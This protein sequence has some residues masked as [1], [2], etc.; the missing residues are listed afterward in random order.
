MGVEKVY[1][2]VLFILVMAAT[3]VLWKFFKIRFDLLTAFIAISLL[4][5]VV[6]SKTTEIVTENTMV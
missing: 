1:C 3:F 5:V 6:M 2:P 4:A